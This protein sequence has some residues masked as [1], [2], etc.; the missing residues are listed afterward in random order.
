VLNQQQ[1]DLATCTTSGLSLGPHQIYA[2]Y[3]GDATF[4]ASSGHH[5]LTVRKAPTTVA[6]TASSYDPIPGQ[7]VIISAT[8]SSRDGGTPTG[9]V[10]FFDGDP[11]SGGT[12]ITCTGSG[13]GVLNQQQPDLATC[14]TSGLSLGPHQIYALYNGD[15]TFLASS[16]HHALTVRKAPTTVL[17]TV[18][19]YDPVV[20]QAVT[21]TTTVSSPAAGMPTGSVTV[22]DGDPASGGTAITCSGSG[23]GVLNQQQPDLATC[24]TSSLSVGTHQIYAVY[25]GGASFLASTNRNHRTV[26]VHAT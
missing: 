23:D 11:S 4:L 6:V 21:I 3:N 19:S 8:V 2:L 26:R 13:D 24:T 17:V 20:G 7:A 14:T 16:G 15:A 25:N 1:P 9:A 12:A 22:Y 10:S 5:A 18:S